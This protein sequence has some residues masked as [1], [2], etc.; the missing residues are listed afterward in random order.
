[1]L[2]NRLVEKFQTLSIPSKAALTASCCCLL[3]AL[4]IIIANHY[5]TKDLISQSGQLHG[6]SLV[7]QLARDA[8]NPLVQ[9]DKLSL[10]AILNRLVESPVIIRGTIYDLENHFHYNR[11]AFFL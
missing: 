6:E 11:I 1:M 9:S 8:R 10:Q 7:R 2:K 5:E 4:I 3:T